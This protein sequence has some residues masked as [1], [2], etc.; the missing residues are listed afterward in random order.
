MLNRSRSNLPLKWYKPSLNSYYFREEWEMF[1]LRLDAEERYNV[2][3]K[4]SY[5][6]SKFNYCYVHDMNMASE[7]S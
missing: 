5:Q 3:N 2:A 4:K 7:A 1:D 6:V